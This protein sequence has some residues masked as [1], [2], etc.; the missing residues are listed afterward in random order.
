MN[1]KNMDKQLYKNR[2]TQLV[3][4]QSQEKDKQYWNEKWIG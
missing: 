3:G 2:H 1:S 4:H